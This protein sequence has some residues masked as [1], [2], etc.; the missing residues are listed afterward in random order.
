MIFIDGHG[1][2]DTLAIDESFEPIFLRETSLSNNPHNV[3]MH[4]DVGE[5]CNEGFLIK[6]MLSLGDG[7]SE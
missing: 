6:M 5:K 1:A 7:R 2:L 4:L 3:S